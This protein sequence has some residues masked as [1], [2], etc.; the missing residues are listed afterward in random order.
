MSFKKLI[1]FVLFNCVVVSA[2]FDE[3][4]L[5]KGTVGDLTP[6]RVSLL[7]RSGKIYIDRKY[8]KK[9][10][11]R[12]GSTVSVQLPIQVILSYNEKQNAK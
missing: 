11:L 8:F 1:A 10:N 12:P 2:G 7:T 5:I 6:E 3:N 4:I 9:E